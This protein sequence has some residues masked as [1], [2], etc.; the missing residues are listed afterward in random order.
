MARDWEQEFADIQEPVP[1]FFPGSSRP[2]IQHQQNKKPKAEPRR[3]TEWDAVP[4][5]YVV[6]GVEVDFFTV[7]Q[8]AAALGRQAVTVRKWE[9]EGVIPKAQFLAPSD[10]P[11]GKRRLY[12]R[13]QVEGI[14]QIADEEGILAVHQNPIGQTQFTKRII[15]LFSSLKGPGQ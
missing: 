5:R 8:L 12:T 4:R 7:G 10:D 15:E 9:R 11:R 14:I 3:T 6:N 1:E 2:I 13:A